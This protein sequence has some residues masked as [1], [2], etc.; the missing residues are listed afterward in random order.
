MAKQQKWITISIILF[1]TFIV[2]PILLNIFNIKIVEGLENLPVNS[3][4]TLGIINNNLMDI[5]NNMFSD[6]D[7]S[8]KI[9]DISGNMIKQI[10]NSVKELSSKLNN[11]PVV[12]A[13]EME[14]LKCVADFGTKIGDDLCCGQSGILSNTKYVCPSEYPKC[15]NMK[16]GKGGSYGSCSK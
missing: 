11:T 8:N 7:A 3:S 12:T 13:P 14:K 10:L 1:I 16:C 15:N 5:S 2:I 9:D 6:E 4:E